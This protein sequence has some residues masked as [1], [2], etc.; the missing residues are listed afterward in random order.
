MIRFFEVASQDEIPKIDEMLLTHNCLIV[1]GSALAWDIPLQRFSKVIEWNTL[2]WGLKQLILPDQQHIA[3]ISTEQNQSQLITESW[4]QTSV[5]NSKQVPKQTTRSEPNISN[6]PQPI[7][8]A[9]PSIQAQTFIVS[10][11]FR[12]D[13]A[14]VGLLEKNG[15]YLVNR[16]LKFSEDAILSARLCLVLYP[17]LTLTASNLEFMTEHL[18]RLCGRYEECLLIMENQ[19]TG[20]NPSPILQLT[21]KLMVKLMPL[22]QKVILRFSFSSQQTFALIQRVYAN[23]IEKYPIQQPHPINQ[24]ETMVKKKKK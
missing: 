24:E 21:H 11:R 6:I 4:I 5:R 14:L 22:W 20:E 13:R 3:L 12:E 9:I 16:D 19:E 10:E 2:V 15:T 17:I 7:L 23:H 1:V 18:H 8:H